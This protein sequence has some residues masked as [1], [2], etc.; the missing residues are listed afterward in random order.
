MRAASVSRNNEILR[1]FNAGETLESIGHSF[2]ITRERVRQIVKKAGAKPRWEQSRERD[3]ALVEKIN[4]LTSERWMT[5]EQVREA[6]GVG[7]NRLNR[8]AKKADI[9]FEKRSFAQEMK[10]RFM[11]ARVRAGESIR[12]AAGGDTYLARHLRDYCAA[13]GVVSRAP[14]RWTTLPEKRVEIIAAMIPTGATWEE[15]TAEIVKVEGTRGVSPNAIQ[16]W[17]SNHAP[18]LRNL[19][20]RKVNRERKPRAV[21]FPKIAR[22]AAP[23]AELI[24]KETV[25]DTAVANYGRVPASHIAKALGTTRNSIIGHWFRARR[26]GEIAA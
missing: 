13:N 16:N 14:C 1:R 7:Y 21:R 11:A 17:C 8:L 19:R 12:S 9:K 15:I 18:H 24:V 4:D 5:R 22:V 20:Q 3:S 26:S 10:L 25:R 2:G 23:I 6:F